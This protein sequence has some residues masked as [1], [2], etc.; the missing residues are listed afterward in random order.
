TVKDLVGAFIFFRD[1][2]SNSFFPV[3]EPAI[4]AGSAFEGWS[5]HEEDRIYQLLVPLKPPCGH[6][7]RPELSDA[8]VG[9][10]RNFRIRVEPVCTCTDEQLAEKMLCFL[11]H[12]EEELRRNQ[13]PSLLDTLCT[14]SYL[15][16][17]KTARWFQQLVK[18]AWA[19]SPLSSQCRL[20]LLP[21]HRSC[22]LQVTKDNTKRFII[23]IIFG[24]RQGFSDVFLSSQGRA[25]IFTRST[26]WPESYAVA[27]AEFF[28]DVAR[29]APHNSCHLK[30][31]Q[32]CARILVGTAFSTST[33]KTVV[34]HLLTVLP[35]SRWRTRDLLPR[36]Q[37]IMR[38]L[39]RCMEDKRLEHFFFGNGNVPD[40]VVLP[41]A[42][43][44]AEPV[45]LFQRLA[46]DPDA[47]TEAL[48]EL[49]EL[50]DR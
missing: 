13:E 24:V 35:M 46:Q 3:L 6:A 42:L 45:N 48:R 31:L 25:D 19:H 4:G 34:M 17:L 50:Q 11:H 20:T 23:E 39:R 41:I 8:G 36:L 18:A 7:F 29:R 22:R 30:C 15:D 2:L 5:P 16:V 47:H 38:Y 21:S 27:E 37:D 12:L 44:T 1:L 32:V 40:E 49:M 14:G 28:R 26:M 9:P 33:L 10:A 43:R